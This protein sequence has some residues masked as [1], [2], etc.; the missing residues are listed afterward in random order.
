MGIMQGTEA[1]PFTKTVKQS[2]EWL[3]NYENVEEPKKEELTPEEVEKEM[4]KLK[5]K[6]ET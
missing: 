2:P 3:K 4:E 1:N 6:F 5:A